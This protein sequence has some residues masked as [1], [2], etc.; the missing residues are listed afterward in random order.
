M[1]KIKSLNIFS[2]S[3]L[4]G[5]LLDG[6]QVRCVE[7]KW[8]KARRSIVFYWGISKPKL[9]YWIDKGQVQRVL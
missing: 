4:K 2:F 6:D 1:V 5:G 9:K 8:S 3:K 7:W